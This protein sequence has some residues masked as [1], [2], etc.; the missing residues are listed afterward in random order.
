MRGFSLFLR[1]TLLALP[2]AVALWLT[3]LFWFALWPELTT[4]KSLAAGLSSWVLVV[5]GFFAITRWPPGQWVDA[6]EQGVVKWF[7]GTKGFGFITRENDEDVFVHFRSIRGRG[8]R[9]LHEGQRVRFGVVMSDKGLQAED[10]SVM[11]ED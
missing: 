7:N 2:L 1:L 5:V 3:H 11:R 4:G 8:H 9:T 10:V 6:R